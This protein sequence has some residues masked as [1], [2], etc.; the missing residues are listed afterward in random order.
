[1]SRDGA[2]P[3][4]PGARLPLPLAP[5]GGVVSERFR[6]GRRVRIFRTGLLA[7]LFAALAHA[8]VGALR[9]AAADRVAQPAR[10][11]ILEWSGTRQIAPDAVTWRVAYEALR[12]ARAISPHDPDLALDLGLLLRIRAQ[13]SAR[14]PALAEML[15]AEALDAFRDAVRLR[16]VS[17]F[18]W[19]NIAYA[20]HLRLRTGTLALAPQ[21]RTLA[22]AERARALERA[23]RYGPNEP[24][25]RRI[26]Q[27][28]ARTAAE[29]VGSPGPSGAM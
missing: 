22:E 17:P 9:N 29:D 2:R 28:I 8:S 16:P 3:E 23:L 26:V 6:R 15:L 10:D 20:Q 1:M 24:A 14:V 11:R 4:A 25:V 5:A 19:A 18:A 13:S 12:R 21:A 27:Q 7:L